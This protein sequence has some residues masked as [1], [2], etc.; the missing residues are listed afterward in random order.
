MGL[1]YVTGLSGT[2]KSAVLDELRARGTL[3]RGVDEEGYADWIDRETGRRAEY[4]RDD[5][6][7]DFHA[8]Y[9]THEWVLSAERIGVLSR[10]AARL[11]GPVFLCGVA[12]GEKAVWHLFDTVVA[13]VADAATLTARITVRDNEFGKAPEE[14]AALLRWHTG[15]E[16][17]YRG[18]GAVI[19]DATRPLGTVVDEILAVGSSR[20]DGLDT[21][22][23][24][25]SNRHADRHAQHVG[26]AR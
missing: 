19:V 5:P 10:A 6:D 16:A 24:G 17:T 1:I 20:T 26:D 7:F 11:G 8:W 25:R 14:L 18:F 4:P 9:R 12:D 23:P 2:G 22:P 15:Y 21:A 3:A 13:L